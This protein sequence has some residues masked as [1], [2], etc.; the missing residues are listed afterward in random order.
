LKTYLDWTPPKT[1]SVRLRTTK[2][3][4]P[5]LIGF[6][7]GYLDCDGY[8]GRYAAQFVGVSKIMMEQ[9]NDILSKMG[10][11]AKIRKY[12]NKNPRYA[13]CYYVGLNKN[14]TIRLLPFLNPR[15]KKRK[16]KEHGAAED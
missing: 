8:V 9:I 7:R 2:L 12:I 6:L 16:L 15:N 5:F 3:P 13:P 4:L 10:F 14:E 11:A 1:Y